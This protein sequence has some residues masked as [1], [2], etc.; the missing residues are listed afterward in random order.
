IQLLP[1]VSKGV[2]GSSDLFVRGGAADQNLVLLDGA[3]VYNTGHLFGFLSVFN[4]DILQGVESINGAFPAYYGG[5][6]SSILNVT[7]KS[8]LVDRTHVSGNIGLLASRLM[9][10]QPIIKNKLHIWIAARRT[11]I[12]QVLSAVNESLPYYFYDLNTKLSFK[13]SSRDYLEVTYYSGQDVLSY[14]REPRDSSRNS[15]RSTDFTIASSTQ[16]VLWRRSI[17]PNVSSELSLYGTRFKYN[18]QNSFQDNR[19]FV[20]SSIRDWGGKWKFQWDSL[21]GVSLFAGIEAIHHSVSPNIISTSGEISELLPSSASEAQ[22]SLESSIFIQADGKWKVRWSWSAGLRLSSA[23]VGNQFYVNP[24]PRLALRYKLQPNTALKFSYSRMSQYLHRVS[25]SAIAFPTD[26]WYPVTKNINPQT[27]DQITLALQQVLPGKSMFVSLEGYYKK[28]N[29]LV[30][31]QE[32][33]NLFL[34]TEFEEQLIQGAGKAYGLEVLIK[35]ESGKLTGWISYTLSRSERK[36]DE[37]NQGQWFFSRYDRR[38]NGAVVMN[39]EFVKRW[40]FS[41]VFE[42]ISGSRFTPIIGQYIVPS[43]TLAGVNLIPV[44]APLNSVKLANTHRLD[45]GIKFR[46]RPERKIQSEWF[47]G[48]YNVY[49]RATPFGITIEPN[50]DGSYR[51]QQPGLFGLLPFV[52]YGFKF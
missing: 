34:N 11:Y 6:L 26:I 15:N 14:A 1:G 27:S 31:Y 9:V 22:T 8:Q 52:S 32:G 13:P 24:E 2:E 28:M 37:V 29:Q 39:Y 42:F 7:T 20:N 43:P 12:D 41:A 49:N 50:S 45:L 30:G 23:N 4:P 16:T 36:Y 10:S 25:S 5:R 47:A 44:Y 51:Y 33:A 38:H 3:P 17:A 46:S 48:V 21:R 18:I 35:K 19:L 40:S